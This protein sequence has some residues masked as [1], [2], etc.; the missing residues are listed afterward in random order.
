MFLKFY[1][2]YFHCSQVDLWKKYIQWE[3]NNPLR[4]EDHAS[5]TK[6]G[7][8]NMPK[9]IR[10]HFFIL[11]CFSISIC[12]KDSVLL[13]RLVNSYVCVWTRI[14]L[15]G[16]S[17]GYVDRSS[18]ISGTFESVTYRKGGNYSVLFVFSWWVKAP[19]MTKNKKYT[20]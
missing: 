11:R 15:L 9:E 16:T 2:D 3:K 8:R 18:I 6:R 12:S 14:T 7:T 13:Y 17:P 1:C 19:T 4:T 10:V 20:Q 5:I